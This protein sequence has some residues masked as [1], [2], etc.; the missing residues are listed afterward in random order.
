MEAENNG[1]NSG[2]DEKGRFGAGNPGKPKG[3]ASNASAKVKQA[4]VDFLE[5]NTENIQETFDKLKPADKLKF[6]ADIL[7]YATPKLSS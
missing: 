7:P 1:N 4:V 2:R 6:I 3:A 5:R